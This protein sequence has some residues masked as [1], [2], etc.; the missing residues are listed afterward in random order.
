[1]NRF[2]KSI[3]ED[4]STIVAEAFLYV[5]TTFMACFAVCLPMYDLLGENKV[6]CTLAYAVYF[7]TWFLT[8]KD[9]HKKA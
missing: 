6:T 8:Y 4:M 2:R 1:M 7:V 3:K 9:L 5:C